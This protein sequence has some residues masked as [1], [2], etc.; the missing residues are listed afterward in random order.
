MKSLRIVKTLLL[1]ILSALLIGFPASLPTISPPVA[2]AQASKTNFRVFNSAARGTTTSSILNISESNATGLIGFLDVTAQAGTNPTLDVVVYDS[3]YS[4]SGPFSVLV[5]FTQVTGATG[6][7]VIAAA[8]SPAKYLKVIG[9]VGGTSTPTFTYT[10]DLLT[11]Y[12]PSVQVTSTQGGAASFT[13]F[14]FSGTNGT[15]AVITTTC[16]EV[17]LATGGLTTDTTANLLPANSIILNV[18]GIVTTTIVTATGWQL[19]VAAVAGR[20][21]ANNTTL[22]AGT[23]DTGSVHW[24][25][26]TTAAGAGPYQAAAAKVRITAAGANPSAGK[27]R[28]CVTAL[29]FTAPTS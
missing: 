13:G 21:T 29:T 28:V 17:T 15:A 1:G 19:G 10:L 20:F 24:N 18:T 27:V 23:R 5:T 22:T 4:T 6:N 3:P 2:H 7:Q 8:R 12:A 11:F 14:T 26:D 16:E 25:A 9:T